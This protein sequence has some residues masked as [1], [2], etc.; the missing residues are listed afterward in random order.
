MLTL[1]DGDDLARLEAVVQDGVMRFAQAGQALAEIRDRRLYLGEYRS[2]DLYCRERWGFTRDRADQLIGASCIY[3]SLA[4]AGCTVLPQNESQVRPLM[5]GVQP[6]Q[7]SEIWAQ[8]VANAGGQ[9]PTRDQVKAV[10]DCADTIRPQLSARVTAND[11]PIPVGSVVQ[12]VKVDRSGKA[13]IVVNADGSEAKLFASEIK[14][15]VT[16]QSLSRDKADLQY[17]RGLISEVLL[18]HGGEISQELKA[19]LAAATN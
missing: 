6:E 13:A 7:R 1:H 15:L 19:R 18:L 16:E 10:R 9:T 11:T 17:L 5:Y 2:F 8:A 14:P 4:A 3:H 12:V